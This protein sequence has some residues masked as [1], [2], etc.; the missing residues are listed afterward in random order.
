MNTRT[1]PRRID[2]LGD[3]FA[4]GVLKA[5]TNPTERRTLFANAVK[6]GSDPGRGN[7]RQHWH[8]DRSIAGGIGRSREEVNKAQTRLQA[9]GIIRRTGNPQTRSRRTAIA[10]YADLCAIG[11]RHGAGVLDIRP[12]RRCAG[13]GI[14]HFTD[15]LL[16]SGILAHLPPAAAEVLMLIC[17]LV[18]PDP[19]APDFGAYDVGAVRLAAIL[20]RHR[21][22][23]HN[24]LTALARDG[25]IA[26]KDGTVI[27]QARRAGEFAQCRPDKDERTR[28]F[29]AAA[30][31]RCRRKRRERKCSADPTP[32]VARSSQ[33]D[34][35][36]ERSAALTYPVARPSHVGARGPHTSRSAALT[37]TTMEPQ[38]RTIMENHR[39][40]SEA[41]RVGSG[42]GNR[43][44]AAP[45]DIW[46]KALREL[47]LQM[48]RTAFET[49]VRDTE[50]VN[51]TGDEITVGA[52]HAYARDWLDKRL[53]KKVEK[54][55]TAAAGR[56]VRV[57]F[58]VR[59]ES[60]PEAA[61]PSKDA[62]GSG[63]RETAPAVPNGARARRAARRAH[64]KDLIGMRS[65]G[66]EACAQVV[67]AVNGAVAAVKVGQLP[68]DVSSRPSFPP[69][70]ALY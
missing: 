35:D 50:I 2:V 67:S 44:G 33:T 26:L 32:P 1:S 59:G 40:A 38:E 24:A 15:R 34:R 9:K 3:I 22:T 54:L 48:P 31:A 46:R 23:V 51:R 30:R 10:E 14:H 49:W 7:Y 64:L 20:H 6:S 63:E 62:A 61:P 70:T 28:P 56:A 25:L 57:S 8:A 12:A 13:A 58:A 18:Q 42:N 41:G 69:S 43:N 55:L 68:A 52:P 21:I 11:E 29:N 45:E 16:E 39:R 60:L 53:R 19:Q 27:L 5:V 37:Q 4:S 65:D 17:W 47:S 66:P 36:Q